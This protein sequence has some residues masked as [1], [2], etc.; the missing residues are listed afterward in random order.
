MKFVK[1]GFS[2]LL[3]TLMIG[4]SALAET[5]V[6]SEIETGYQKKDVSANESKFEQ[7][8]EVP[9]GVVIPLLTTEV[10]HDSDTIRFEGQNLRQNNQSY[11]LNY[12][13]AYKMKVDALWNQTPHDY[14]NVAQTLYTETSPGVFRLPGQIQSN[15]QGQPG[16]T[17][18]NLNNQLGS[19]WTA[20]HDAGLHTLDNKGAVNLGFAASQALKFNLGVSE[21]N[22]SGHKPKGASFGFSYVN[23]LPEPI[24]WKTYNVRAGGQYNTKDVQLGLYYVMSSFNNDVETMIWDSA[25]RSTDQA[26]STIGYVYGDQSSQ[27]RMNLAPDNFSH[28]VTLNAGANLPAKTR[29]TAEGSMGYMRQNQTLLPFTINT[30]IK[31]GAAN[32]PPFDA[33]DP[34]N[35]SMQT[36]NTK[37]QTW[38]QDYQLTNQLIKPVTL[39]LRYHSYQLINRATETSFPG[40]VRFDQVWEPAPGFDVRRFE[41]RKDTLEGNADYQVFEPLCLSVRYGIEWDHRT[42]REISDTTEKSLTASADYKPAAWTLFRGSYL[43]AH[44]RPQD[45]DNTF[46]LND[47]GTAYAELPGL[48]RYDVS[49]R[50]RNQGKVLWQLNPG[51]M[52]IGLN[53]SLTHDN[54]QPGVGD[55]TGNDALSSVNFPATQ[56]GL[57][58]NRDASAGV[59]V[60][61]DISDRLGV[62]T[63]Y[64]YEQVKGLQRSNQG[65]GA[66]ITQAATTDWTL[67]SLDR[68]QMTGVSARIGTPADR[69]SY[70]LGYDIT[71]SRGSIEYMSI[72][73]AVTP[74]SIN[75]PVDTKY[76]KQDISIRTNVKVTE[77][78]T[79]VLGYLYEKFDVSDWQYQNLP[80]VGGTA[81][82]Q[83]NVF[84]GNNL[85]NYFAHVGTVL[86]K[87]KF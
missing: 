57:L 1:S 37:M 66:T 84:L 80:L 60:E 28:T 10:V 46:N 51:P 42:D 21:D 53:G 75:S 79:L 11:D 40:Q 85:Q 17:V 8:G 48:R 76:M 27:G 78:C 31:P 23:Q 29:F 44:R 56:Y 9:D 43:R 63:Y 65:S 62:D 26:V 2:L 86:V 15:I 38:S 70:R 68:Y 18:T 49:D 6:S 71:M 7:Y 72:G 25:R 24:E 64:D 3:S 67:Q 52:T 30:A 4:S 35:L 45:F 55:P 41:Y 61:W 39:G 87:Y 19:Y 81:S 13:H 5:Q 14:S 83:T 20:A 12:N 47:P 22:I 58:E 74:P 32:A 69:V 36:A 59:D 34:A 73:S 77:R 50:L 16:I 33:S 54:F 82:A